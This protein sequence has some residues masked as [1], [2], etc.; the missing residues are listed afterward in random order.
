[1]P[2]YIVERTFPNGLAI[3][4]NAQGAQACMTVV[5]VNAQAGVTWV[6]SYVSDDKRRRSASTTR[7]RR[8]RSARWRT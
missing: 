8:R 5:G 7:R 4:P 3:P 6:H 1:M 2:R